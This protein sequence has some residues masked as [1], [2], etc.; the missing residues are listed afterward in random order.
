MNKIKFI[1]KTKESWKK[2]GN[3]DPRFLEVSKHE[4]EIFLDIGTRDEINELKSMCFILSE[5]DAKRFR[6]WLMD[7][8]FMPLEE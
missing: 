3:F 7:L 6:A 1:Y 5:K 8:D 4:K 2:E